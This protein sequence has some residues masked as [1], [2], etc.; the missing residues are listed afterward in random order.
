MRLAIAPASNQRGMPS[1][2]CMA[3]ICSANRDSAERLPM[4]RTSVHSEW[5]VCATVRFSRFPV[6]IRRAIRRR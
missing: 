4:V 1:Q 3:T 2:R 5:R 6:E